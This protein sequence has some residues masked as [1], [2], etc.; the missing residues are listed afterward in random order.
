MLSK[1]RW[2]KTTLSF[3]DSVSSG[4]GRLLRHPRMLQWSCCARRF[5]M[6]HHPKKYQQMPPSFH[7]IILY[8]SKFINVLDMKKTHV[9]II[10]IIPILWWWFFHQ[11]SMRHPIHAHAQVKTLT[12]VKSWTFGSW[13][14]TPRGAGFWWP[15]AASV[16]RRPRRAAQR[17]LNARGAS[18]TWFR[19]SQHVWFVWS[20][21]SQN[22]WEEWVL[23]HPHMEIYIYILILY[24]FQIIYTTMRTY[25]CNICILY[26]YIINTYSYIDLQ[27]MI[28]I[29]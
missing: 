23:I 24:V 9:N 16:P 1:H 25:I 6:I 26:I 3:P 12:W 10:F 21:N 22:I 5:S 13:A 14:W 7:Y 8:P 11:D 18:A 28:G 29:I 20:K 17:P 19:R 2:Y 27:Y 4:L 15:P